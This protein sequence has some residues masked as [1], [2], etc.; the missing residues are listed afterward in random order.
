MQGFLFHCFSQHPSSSSPLLSRLWSLFDLSLLRHWPFLTYTAAI[1]LFNAG[2]FI[3][4]VHLV[5][6]IQRKG[7][8]EYQAALVMSLTALTDLLGRGVSGWVSD[9]RRVRL[10]HILALWTGLTGLSM[11]VIPLGSS[12]PVLLALGLVYGFCSGAMTPVVFSL[13]PDIV[14]VGRIFGAL[15]LLQMIESVGGL[16]GSPLSGE[17]GG[18]LRVS[19]ESMFFLFV[20][21]FYY[22]VQF[23]QA[24]FLSHFLFLFFMSV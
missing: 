12:Y 1:T 6:H 22:I 18:A 20:F 15:G 21:Q 7:F 24:S 19:P 8:S 13:L 9:L 10:P 5:A 23:P 17:R 11:L 4:Y 14:G 16:L 2:Y 3:P